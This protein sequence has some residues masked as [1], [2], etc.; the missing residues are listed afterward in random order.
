[1]QI[2]GS[3]SVAARKKTTEIL[4]IMHGMN[5]EDAQDSLRAALKVVDLFISEHE[6][7]RLIDNQ[8]IPQD[9]FLRQFIPHKKRVFKGQA[10][11]PDITKDDLEAVLELIRSFPEV[12]LIESGFKEAGLFGTYIITAGDWPKPLRIA[13]AARFPHLKGGLNS[14]PIY[15][16]RAAADAAMEEQRANGEPV[17]APLFLDHGP[18]HSEGTG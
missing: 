3:I 4:A 18:L 15:P 16:D 9:F 12:T 2:T 8:V 10:M 1:M 6:K 13:V 11:E 7:K 14:Y 5:T 17:T